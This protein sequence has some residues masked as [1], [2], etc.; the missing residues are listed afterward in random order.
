MPGCFVP[1]ATA[2][3]RTWFV[4]FAKC[5]VILVVTLES[6][7]CAISNAELHMAISES[8]TDSS[9]WCANCSISKKSGARSC[10]ARDGAWFNRC[11]DVGDTNFD[12]TWE[13]G[14][15]ACTSMLLGCR[16][17]RLYNYHDSH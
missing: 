3:T 10:C 6:V 17:A 11:G 9:N 1:I 15:Q 5:K 14:I 8:A 4:G 7:F 16:E 13:E 12:H 2:G